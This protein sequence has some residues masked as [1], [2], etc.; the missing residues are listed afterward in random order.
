M[1]SLFYLKAENEEKRQK[2]LK[3]FFK[4]KTVFA[5]FEKIANR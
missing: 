5:I 4:S 3:L 2:N 1:G